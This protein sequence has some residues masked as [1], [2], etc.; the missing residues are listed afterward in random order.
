MG[1]DLFNKVMVIGIILLFFGISYAPTIAIDFVKKSSM[2]AVFNGNILYV[3]G[4]GE[5][6]YSKIRNAVKNASDGD[7]IFVYNG[8]Y[9]EKTIRL[10]KAIKLLGENS[11]TTFLDGEIS[12]GIIVS[13]K[14]CD[15]TISGFTFQRCYEDGFGEAIYLW[16]KS[17]R[18]ENIYISDCIIKEC[19]RGIYYD[20]VDNLIVTNCYFYNNIGQIGY[21]TD[22]SNIKISNCLAHNNGVEF[23]ERWVTPG[24]FEFDRCSDVEIFNCTLYYNKGFSISFWGGNNLELYQN[25]IYQNSWW[26]VQFYGYEAALY[27]IDFHDN[28]IHDNYHS[29]IFVSHVTDLGINI[30]NNNFS[31]NGYDEE[32]LDGGIYIQSCY[33][34]VIIQYN[35]ITSN[36]GFGIRLNNGNSII[37]NDIENNTKQGILISNGPLENTLIKK[38]IIR[39]NKEGIYLGHELNIV[40]GN[41]ISDNECGINISREENTILRNEFSGNNIGVKLQG[42]H[43][44]LMCNNISYNNFFDNKKDVFFRIL[45]PERP[46]RIII[47]SNYWD[48]SRIFPKPILGIIE[49]DRLNF[50]IYWFFFDWHPAKKPFDINQDFYIPI[51]SFKS[52]S[53]NYEE[54]SKICIQKS[55]NILEGFPSLLSYCCSFDS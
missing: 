33:D 4:T 16:N 42:R 38:N 27:N 55:I 23:G 43:Y 29:G 48:R 24:A 11:S 1:K 3:G 19:D 17:G 34:S 12:V 13:I 37:Q 31:S 22:S 40:S 2:A 5:G 54:Y 47:N 10:D 35:K 44:L 8:V 53:E 26:G 30:Y 7:T 50:R 15:I 51:D 36:N 39:N 21:G 25:H 28:Y 20:D 49:S 46:N 45:E 52:S 41:T 6:N 18:L 32:S 14:S 9:K